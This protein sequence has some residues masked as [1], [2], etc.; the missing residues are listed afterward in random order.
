M[1]RA[2]AGA[3]GPLDHHVLQLRHKETDE[4][5]GSLDDGS[6]TLS[7]FLNFALA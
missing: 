4:G 1:M 6:N 3:A 2:K 7:V 5:H